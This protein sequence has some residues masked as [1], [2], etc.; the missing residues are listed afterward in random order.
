MLEDH[1]IK[2]AICPNCVSEVRVDVLHEEKTSWADEHVD[3]SDRYWI[4][5]C[6]GCDRIFFGHGSTFSEVTD[7]EFNPNTGEWYLFQPEEKTFYPRAIKR[8]KPDWFDWKFQSKH[9]AISTVLVEVYS[10]LDHGLLMLSA[11]GIRTVFDRISDSLHINSAL[12]FN[13]KI[14]ELRSKQHIT[15]RERDMLELLVDAGGAAI[16]AGWNPTIEDL[17]T[18]MEIVEGTIHRA[19]V[20]PER[21]E[22]IR[23]RL[24]PKIT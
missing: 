24:P 20:L 9:D 1:D 14:E 19:L 23:A 7:H 22:E 18:L 11:V 5:R 10:S 17:T 12:P 6:R 21:A 3:G 2:T 4:L 15:G 13:K 16:H 8:R